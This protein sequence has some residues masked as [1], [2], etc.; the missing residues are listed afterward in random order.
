M[1]SFFDFE[2]FKFNLVY[3]AIYLILALISYFLFKKQKILSIL[4]LA[5]LFVKVYPNLFFHLGFFIAVILSAINRKKIKQKD[6]ILL[7]FCFVLCSKSIFAI[8]SLLYSNFGYCL[9]IF[10]IIRQMYLLLNKKWV[11]WQFVVLFVSLS[12]G[13]FFVYFN[14][15]KVPFK[16]DIGT[17]WLFNYNY[18]LFKQID[19]YLKDNLKKGETFI[20]L[21]EGQILNLIYKTPW[22]FYNSTF[23]PL[24]FEIFG[25]KNLA[26]RLKENKTDYIIFYPRNT[27]EYGARAIC[28]DYAV[29]FCKFIDD[30]YK[31][32]AIF[33]DSAEVLIYKIN[34][35]NK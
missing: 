27:E 29:D 15:P 6:I 12:V 16:T 31:R 23:T 35:K 20:V 28:F 25:D 2:Y 17:I 4:L 32:D 18:N 10:Y 3:L 19:G 9:M 5:F 33:G 11:I 21:P 1:G 24:D 26:E 14:N 22:G 30:N 7:F 34:E 13:Q 8:D